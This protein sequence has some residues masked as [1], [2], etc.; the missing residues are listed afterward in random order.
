MTL[1][2]KTAKQKV[3]T[4]LFHKQVERLQPT[5]TINMVYRNTFIIQKYQKI[6]NYLFVETSS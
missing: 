6:Y 2:F 3:I 4:L 5:K 1:L